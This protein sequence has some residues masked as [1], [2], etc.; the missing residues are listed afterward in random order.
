MP[1]MP[2]VQLPI[3]P[4]GASTITAELGFERREQQVIYLNGHLP[5]GK[6]IKTEGHRVVRGGRASLLAA[7]LPRINCGS[8][9][10]K[11]QFQ[12]GAGVRR[13]HGIYAN[14]IV[15]SLSFLS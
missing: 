3:F 2:Q 6:E 1:A 13:Q 8:F 14:G 9:T 15:E 5:V 11:H 10:C 7:S 4:V 12:L